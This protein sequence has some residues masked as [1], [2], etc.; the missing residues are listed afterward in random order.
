MSNSLKIT[1]TLG[2]D[3]TVEDA[4]RLHD[5]VAEVYFGDQT[6]RVIRQGEVASI[7]PPRRYI[8]EYESP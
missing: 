1:V 8:S 3:Q 7:R 6:Y 4:V 5:Q 2:R